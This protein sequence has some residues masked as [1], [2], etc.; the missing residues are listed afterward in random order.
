MGG[1]AIDKGGPSNR[2]LHSHTVVVEKE[3][4]DLCRAEPSETSDLYSARKF[5]LPL[6]SPFLHTV[7]LTPYMG[8]FQRPCK[9]QER[10]SDM[11]EDERRAACDEL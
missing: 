4:E 3:P 5:I 7:R 8:F 10:W 1:P 6:Y 2:T 9:L 11:N